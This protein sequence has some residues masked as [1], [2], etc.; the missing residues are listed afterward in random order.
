MQRGE[1]RATIDR[2]RGELPAG[3]LLGGPAAEARD[4]E[5]ALVSRLP[6]VVG[7]VLGLSFVLLRA[8]LAA[9]AVV[10]LSLLATTAAFG[11][12][13]LV[14]QEGALDRLLGFESPEPEPAPG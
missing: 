10:A 5:S 14:F 3:A 9:A 7:V 12:A 13:R 2:V 1:L 6:V 4:L 8:P 11:V